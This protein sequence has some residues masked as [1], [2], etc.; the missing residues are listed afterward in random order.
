MVVEPDF[1]LYVFLLRLYM[2]RGAGRALAYRFMCCSLVS[3]RLSSRLATYYSVYN[4]KSDPTR[5]P[6]AHA[7]R[8]GVLAARAA[9]PAGHLEVRGAQVAPTL[10]PRGAPR[11]PLPAPRRRRAP[12]IARAG[13]RAH[14][15]RADVPRKLPLPAETREAPATALRS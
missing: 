3:K 13:Q 15:R 5:R 11:S 10:T 12:A 2:H 8:G 6:H 14:A 1:S 9:A 4:R 7:S